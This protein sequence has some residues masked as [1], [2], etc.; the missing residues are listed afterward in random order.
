[1]K[2]IGTHTLHL[3]RGSSY[4]KIIAFEFVDLFIFTVELNCCL[5]IFFY[6]LDA[7]KMK[8]HSFLSLCRPLSISLISWHDDV[9]SKYILWTVPTY[10]LW[11]DVLFVWFH[12]AAE[13]GSFPTTVSTSLRFIRSHAINHT[14]NCIFYCDHKC[15]CTTCRY[16]DVY[17]NVIQM[18]SRMAMVSK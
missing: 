15:T 18:L 11:V 16:L 8:Q 6:D 17:L 3:H 4:N 1:M 5:L 10:A 13:L 12:C 9:I 2:D 7:D 14:Y